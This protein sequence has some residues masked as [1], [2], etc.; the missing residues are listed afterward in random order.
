VAEDKAGGKNSFNFDFQGNLS[1]QKYVGELHCS[2]EGF[3]DTGFEDTNAREGRETG[4]I[5]S[6]GTDKRK[7][8]TR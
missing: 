8:L 3:S 1:S 7:S 2:P 5:K 6:K 4:E